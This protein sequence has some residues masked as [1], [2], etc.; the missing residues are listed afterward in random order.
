[1]TVRG[2]ATTGDVL[3]AMKQVYPWQIWQDNEPGCSGS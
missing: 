3:N 2:V 1:M